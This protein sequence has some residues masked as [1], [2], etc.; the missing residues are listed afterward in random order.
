MPIVRVFPHRIGL[1]LNLVLLVFKFIARKSAYIRKNIFRF[2]VYSTFTF[3]DQVQTV[4]FGNKSKLQVS[5]KELIFILLE[6][7]AY[8][9][10]LKRI[11]CNYVH[12]SCLY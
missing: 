5:Y 8:H 11:E 9:A 3:I 4:W 2:H 1:D 10:R 7:N 6:S 12:S